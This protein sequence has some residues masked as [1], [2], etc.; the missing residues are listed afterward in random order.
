MSFSSSAPNTRTS[1]GCKVSTSVNITDRAFRRPFII[2]RAKTF[3][4][5]KV[6]IMKTSVVVRTIGVLTIAFGALPARAQLSC[7]S[8]G[9]NQDHMVTHCEMREQTVGYAGR[10]SVDPGMN[11]GV[12]IKA[13]SNANVLVRSKVES[14][15]SDDLGA[16]A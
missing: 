4:L 15:A 16:R 13:W 1:M 12:S 2:Q 11:G 9:F 14:A 3:A 7:D 5:R 6:T 10:L 8:K